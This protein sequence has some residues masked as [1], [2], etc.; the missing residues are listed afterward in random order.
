ML[1]GLHGAS[2]LKILAILAMNYLI[3]KMCGGAPVAP[4]ATWFFNITVLFMN[5]IHD[6]Y[7]FG[8]VLPALEALV[9]HLPQP[10]TITC[11]ETSHPLLG[12]YARVLSSLERHLQYHDAAADFV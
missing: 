9:R 3:A 11:M 4:F 7:K 2:S 1:I 10:F 5:E 6:G 12:Q 8:A